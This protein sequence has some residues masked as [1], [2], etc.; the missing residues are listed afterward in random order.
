[1]ES[2]RTLGLKNGEKCSCLL[3]LDVQVLTLM[4]PTTEMHQAVPQMVCELHQIQDIEPGNVL[5]TCNDWLIPPGRSVE[6]PLFGLSLSLQISESPRRA[7]GWILRRL[8]T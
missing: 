7:R 3:V 2:G 8:P 6:I 1:M 5:E 4:Q